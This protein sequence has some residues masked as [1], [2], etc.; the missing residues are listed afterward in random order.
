[1]V[2]LESSSPPDPPDDDAFSIESFDVQIQCPQCGHELVHDG[3]TLVL[4]ESPRGVMF[5]CGRCEKI[6]EWKLT[7]E[8]FVA[9]NVPVVFGG[10]I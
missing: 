10:E 4:A 8:P 1:M 5:E 2:L 9:T 3:N 7:W 6:S